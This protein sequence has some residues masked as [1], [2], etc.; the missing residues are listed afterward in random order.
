M[1]A[2]GRLYDGEG[3]QIDHY[4][5][6]SPNYFGRVMT[7]FRKKSQDLKTYQ[8]QSNEWNKKTDPLTRSNEIPDEEMVTCSYANYLKIGQWQL[9]YPGCY[10]TLER[11]GYGLTVE[12]GTK[13]RALF[14]QLKNAEKC[15][16]FPED[17][18]IQFKKWL[19]GKVFDKFIRDG[20]NEIRL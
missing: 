7:A 1:N 5:S 3:K 9:I 11:H 12:E 2:A 14:N 13:E 18:E 4:Q 15:G 8:Q 10:K 19:T 16:A 6:F 17:R 20:K